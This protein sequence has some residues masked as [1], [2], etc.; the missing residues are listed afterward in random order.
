MVRELSYATNTNGNELREVFTMRKT[1]GL[2]AAGSLMVL[3]ILA[4]C[5]ST[6]AS[7]GEHLWLIPKPK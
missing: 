1:N 7:A 6:V 4:V 5:G 2:A 3:G